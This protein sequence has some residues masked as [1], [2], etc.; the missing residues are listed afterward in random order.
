MTIPDFNLA[1]Y[2]MRRSAANDDRIQM[3]RAEVTVNLGGSLYS[4]NAIGSS[5]AEIS[6]SAQELAGDD[7][8]G[9]TVMVLQ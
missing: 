6:E 7:P 9:V 2:E 8:F 4:F 3:I 5:I 1:A